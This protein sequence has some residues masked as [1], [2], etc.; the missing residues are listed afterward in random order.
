MNFW[1]AWKF[2]WENKRKALFPLGGVIMGAMALVMTLALGEGAKK[3]I[4]G[5]LS[6]LGRNRILL[7][8]NFSSRDL[9]IIEK[10]PFVE[11]GLFPQM[12]VE[13]NDLIF[14]GYGKKALRAMGLRNLKDGEIIL[15]REQ[16]LE[17]RV[18]TQKTL[19]IGQGKRTF[20]IGD[21]YEEESPFERARLGKRVLMGEETFIRNFGRMNYESLVVSFPRGEDGVEYIPVILRE[22][23][24]SR[25]KYNQVRVLETPDV[26]KKV[27]R[28]RGFVSKGLFILS[29]I[30]LMVGGFGVMNL[31]GFS[32]YERGSYI[33]IMKTMGVSREDI[34]KIFLLE[35]TIL[36]ITGTV[37]GSLLGIVMGYLVG[38]F[39]G[40]PGYFKVYEIILSSLLIMGVGLL[41]GIFPAR[42]A[43]NME[44]V[45]A[46][47]I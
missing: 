37:I 15:D 26:Y 31:I 5:D 32:V 1:M 12:R 9:A 28:I 45:E 33:G 29:F 17:D 47:K 13:T 6:A 44:I 35:G 7:G 42:R 23:N 16:F 39:I 43:G 19:E 40:I 22:L 3:V 38:K 20:I 41:F 30:S 24:R 21:F 2:L 4:D 14:R 27:E 25:L 18:G 36:V 11:Y 46:L 10:L 34:M 8:G